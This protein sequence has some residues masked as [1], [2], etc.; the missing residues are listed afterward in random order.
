MKVYLWS[1][2]VLIDSVEFDFQMVFVSQ[3]PRQSS[4]DVDF[5]NI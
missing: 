5:D 1:Y 4:P 2:P 3:K